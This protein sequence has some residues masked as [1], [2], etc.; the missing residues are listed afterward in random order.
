MSD[1]LQ[2]VESGITLDSDQIE[3]DEVETETP[4]DGGAELAPATGEDQSKTEDSKAQAQE[5]AQ[6][7][8]NKQHAK[9]REEERKRIEM[10]EKLKAANKKLEAFEAEK[11]E[12]TIPPVPDT[13]DE[14]F[15]EKLKQRD[16]AIMQKA[17]QDA[18]KQ[19]VVAQQTA[20]EEAVAKV[21]EERV[22]TLIGGYSQ[23]INTLGLNADE[24]RVA[25]DTV[26]RNGIDGS[27]AE[28]ILG[29]EDGPL[30]TKYLAEN[31]VIQDELRHLP[32]IQAAMKIDS[33][34]RQ[35]VSTMKP[36]VSDAPDPIETLDGRGAGE[37]VS[38][39]IKGAT[40]E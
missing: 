1:E 16:E 9:Y 39:F 5:M 29:D 20:N 27:V 30:I 23:R 32:P 26:V 37:Q 13:F 22:Q 2:T 15:E 36:Q 14:D 3:T 8:I 6:K 4:K 10:E 17:Q 33:T 31:P 25:G 7:A 12:I 21:E 18:Q 11:G 38:R 40:F 24:V 34:I 35:A 19:S 28:Y